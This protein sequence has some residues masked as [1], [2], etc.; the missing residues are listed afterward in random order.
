M[1][2]LTDNSLDLPEAPSQS[3]TI[4]DRTSSLE[5]MQQVCKWATRCDQTHTEKCRR[6][7]DQF[8]PT[9]LID[10]GNPDAPPSW[11]PGSLKL[12]EFEPA[13]VQRYVTLSHC[14]G[15]KDFARLLAS[16]LEEY[17]TYGIQ[18]SEI[19]RNTNFRDAIEVTRRLNVR[20]IWIDSLCIIQDSEGHKDWEHEAPLM[21]MVYRNS[22]CNIAASDSADSDG[23][24]FRLRA[25]KDVVLARYPVHGEISG[26]SLAGAWR[27]LHSDVW[28]K[29]LLGQVLYGRG[30]VFQGTNI[31]FLFSCSFLFLLLGNY[32]SKH[33]ASVFIKCAPEGGTRTHAAAVDMSFLIERMLAP[34]AIHFTSTQIFW[35]CPTHSACESL[36]RGIPRQLDR[37]ASVDRNWRAQLQQQQQPEKPGAASDTIAR[38]E[39]PY[40]FWRLAVRKY[41]SCALTFHADKLKALWGIAQLVR[42]SRPRGE[43]FVAGLWERDLIEQ[44]AWAVLDPATS[45]RPPP[46]E[47]SSEVPD[48]IWF[49][50]WSWASVTGEVEVVDLRLPNMCYRARGHNGPDVV[51]PTGIAKVEGGLPEI[52]KDQAIIQLQC[53]RCKGSLAKAGGD[54][55]W[56]MKISDSQQSSVSLPAFPDV[57]PSPNDLLGNCEFLLLMQGERISALEDDG[58]ILYGKGIRE[59]CRK[60]YSGMGLLVKRDTDVTRSDYV[61]RIGMVKFGDMSRQIWET[62]CRACGQEGGTLLAEGGEKLNLV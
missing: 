38:R 16:N 30:W 13:D 57:S 61:K 58:S 56:V 42:E 12:V 19:C 28:D 25:S 5:S 48:P 22:Y 52:P 21:H 62:I 39:I 33:S 60:V 3:T 17:K 27:I 15:R 26:G 45:Q 32:N 40:E 46:V 41:T 44:L 8:V 10:V 29:D 24:L 23:G 1:I 43:R 47:P 37:L 59:D 18:W 4:G 7:D 50:S 20:Y 36:P 55:G 49:P 6:R 2:R 51:A 31:L 34:R 54:T 14:W 35:D 11:P 9:R 53:Y